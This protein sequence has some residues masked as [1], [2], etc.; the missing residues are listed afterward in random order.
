[1]V[2]D[3]LSRW[4]VG[5][6]GR[7]TI[8]TSIEPSGPALSPLPVRLHCRVWPDVGVDHG[9]RLCDGSGIPVDSDEATGGP[10]RVP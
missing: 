3:L 9:L 8:A 2:D 4:F 7:R 1:M 6:R 10:D 5:P